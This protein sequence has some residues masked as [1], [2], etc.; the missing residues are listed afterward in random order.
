M[1]STLAIV[2]FVLAISVSECVAHCC[3]KKYNMDERKKHLYFTAIAFYTIVCAMLVLS[4]KYNGLGIIN[5]MWSGLSAL[6]GSVFFGVSLKALHKFGI[7]LI[8]LG[9]TCVLYEN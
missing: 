6:T 1:N 4:Y 8:L 9:I 5:I 2:L 3:L 7:L